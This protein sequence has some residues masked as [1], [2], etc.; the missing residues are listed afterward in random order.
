MCNRF[1]F[2]FTFILLLL[3]TN[4]ISGQLIQ[5]KLEDKSHFLVTSHPRIECYKVNDDL[6]VLK[7]KI[8]GLNKY[9]RVNYPQDTL[10]PN[11]EI[12]ISTVDTMH[13]VNMLRPF[14]KLINIMP[15]YLLGEK[16]INGPIGD[17]NNNGRI[18]YYCFSFSPIILEYNPIDSNFNLIYKYQKYYN[19]IFFTPRNFLDYDNDG[20]IETFVL[21][22]DSKNEKHAL[23]QLKQT[24]RF[25]LPTRVNLIY[26]DS[27]SSFH[28]LLPF[29]L[30]GDSLYELI[31]FSF[32]ERLM[33][34]AKYSKTLNNYY[35]A[36]R[37]DSLYFF[38]VANYLVDDFD[39][40]GKINILTSDSDGWIYIHE[41]TD[42][43]NFKFSKFK[44]NDINL[45]D[46][47]I[48][49][50]L[51]NNGFDE[52]WIAS[53]Y[54]IYPFRT[55]L[56][57]FEANG[58]D[59]YV[60]KYIIQING[61]YKLFSSSM[62]A[63]DID[64]DG[65]EE[66]L[67]ITDHIFYIFKYL[68]NG[69][70]DLYYFKIIDELRQ[71]F[72]FI[73]FFL[74]DLENDGI[75][76]IFF[77]TEYSSFITYKNDFLIRNGEEIDYSPDTTDAITQ[78]YKINFLSTDV[79]LETVKEFTIYQNYP[80][81]FNSNTFISFELPEEIYL[82]VKV[83]NLIGE[84][85]RTLDSS[86]YKAGQYKIQWDGKDNHKRDL[87]SGIYLIKFNSNKF[88]KTIKAVLLR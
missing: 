49:K 80:N 53:S 86:I 74:G 45:F 64:K 63:Y 51:D 19:Y 42:N 44:I 56:Y 34:I 41:M 47:C 20:L 82:E 10:Y 7:D 68:E 69:N 57:Q 4:I 76:E 3:T 77:E 84:E 39:K 71:N 13:Y 40:D 29:D 24:N 21:G 11:L 14:K 38:H 62:M 8:T 65:K 54:F 6:V 32:D 30:D 26:F 48:T 85:V 81:P 36:Y 59:S 12:Y 18:E 73:E 66:I 37:S 17:I 9:L 87:P 83:Y 1:K 50:D 27:L 23:L 15:G 61:D 52:I 88:S 22:Y 46:K 5:S 60:L 70:F 75:P 33:K 67:F 79:L 2:C 72:V 35:T 16:I 78:I 25:D 58:N 43:F 31:H 55:R 28:S